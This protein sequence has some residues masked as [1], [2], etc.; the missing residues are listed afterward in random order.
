[1]IPSI[2]SSFVDN[3]QIMAQ[4]H[5]EMNKKSRFILRVMAIVLIILALTSILVGIFVSAGGLPFW[6][7]GWLVASFGMLFTS[8]SLLAITLCMHNVLK[9]KFILPDPVI[10]DETE[11]SREG[12]PYL[13]VKLVSGD[14]DSNSENVSRDEVSMSVPHESFSVDEVPPPDIVVDSKLEALVHEH[15][16]LP[17]GTVLDEDHLASLIEKGI[18]IP[19]SIQG[20]L[21]DNIAVL[22]A[23]KGI[24]K[25]FEGFNMKQI[26]ILA[27]AHLGLKPGE[28]ISG[29]HLKALADPSLHSEE[30]LSGP[31]LDKLEALVTSNG[32]MISTNLL[33]KKDLV[34]L[35]N[36]FAHLPAGTTLNGE[37]LQL[38]NDSM[39]PI[40]PFGGKGKKK[41]ISE[42]S[43]AVV[44]KKGMVG[45]QLGTST[46]ITPSKVAGKPQIALPAALDPNP[47]EVDPDGGFLKKIPVVGSAI[48]IAGNVAGFIGHRMQKLPGIGGAI[49]NALVIADEIT[50]AD[51]VGDIAKIKEDVDH[52]RVVV[53]AI[54]KEKGHH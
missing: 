37:Q 33:S 31:L 30:V 50:D 12:L 10:V 20:Q 36:K 9:H 17:K 15:L 18:P 7:M 8:C 46:Q 32:A 54:K 24:V 3:I 43:L 28:K 49:G 52:E 47:H 16:D 39:L 51:D 40:S 6:K 2:S 38:I 35:A 45:G 13:R 53:A 19:G 21:M 26:K 25:P 14:Q 1:M 22:A 41:G 4:K 5:E 23:E 44:S 34:K 11:D 42:Q 27:Q 29:A 48:G